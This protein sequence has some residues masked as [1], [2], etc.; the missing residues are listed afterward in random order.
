MKIDPYVD[1]EGN[2]AGQISMWDGSQHGLFPL[3]WKQSSNNVKFIPPFYIWKE[4]KI[5]RL[6]NEEVGIRVDG[7]ILSVSRY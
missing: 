6:D 2:D 4:N 7:P 5:Q 3:D 1:A